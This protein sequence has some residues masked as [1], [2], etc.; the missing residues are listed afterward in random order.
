MEILQDYHLLFIGVSFAMLFISILFLF[1]NNTKE[2]MFGALILCGL[3]YVLCIFNSY[4]FFRIGIVGY[5]ADTSIVVNAYEEMFPVYAV[6]FLLYWINILLIFYCW[7]L[8]VRN[9]WKIGET[10]SSEVNNLRD[11]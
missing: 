8:W 11:I 3:N 9:P 1:V 2:K 5:S 6:F 10:G 7:W 4:G